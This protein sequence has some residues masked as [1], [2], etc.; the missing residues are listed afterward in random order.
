MTAVDIATR[1]DEKS[2][3]PI[4]PSVR[5]RRPWLAWFGAAWLLLVVGLALL[6]PLLPMPGYE[7]P[8]GPARGAPEASLQG[9]LGYDDLGRSMLSRAVYGGRVSLLMGAASGLIGFTVGTL[10]GLLAGFVRGSVDAFIS[11]LADGLLAFPPLILLLALAAVVEP[12]ITTL[13]AA[14]SVMVIPTFI[15]LSR[16]NTLRWANREFVMAATNLGAGPVR[17]MFREVL[18]NLLTSLAA[19][20]PIVIA[21]LIIAEGSLSFL[22]M[23][24]PAP[25]PSWGGMIESGRQ[26]LATFPLLV[27]VPAMTIFLT[28]LSLNVVGD[29]LR[30]KLVEDM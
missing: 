9:L 11:F 26:Y 19:V 10:L 6:A 4:L 21:S 13:V 25:T 22:G 20:L 29:Q 14:L 28:V 2:E 23:G 1:I 12:S 8:V 27:L 24:I 5:R 18:P 7:M 15:R 30:G 16:A 17:L 3:Q